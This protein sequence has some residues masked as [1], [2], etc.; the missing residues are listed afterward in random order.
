[1]IKKLSSLLFLCFMFAAHADQLSDAIQESDLQKV[2]SLLSELTL[3]DKQLTKYLDSAEQ[4]IKTRRDCLHAKII[5][6]EV[7]RSNIRG[8]FEIAFLACLSSSGISAI[9]RAYNNTY[10]D[11]GT[12]HFKDMESKCNK[13][14]LGSPTG[15]TI[16]MIAFL[17]CMQNDI[18]KFREH[19][20][21][22]Y[23]NAIRIKELLYDYNNTLHE[24]NE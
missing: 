15:L 21:T 20:S 14:M 8:C 7:P 12:S 2:T 23:E 16:I 5:L 11:W 10:N 22:L 1:M 6:A 3:T 18:K 19:R 17:I 4:V 9:L 24:N 13:A